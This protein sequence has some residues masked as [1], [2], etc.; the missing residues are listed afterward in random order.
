MTIKK[1]LEDKTLTAIE[2]IDGFNLI[3]NIYTDG[4][5]NGLN[6]DT[7]NINSGTSLTVHEDFTLIDD[8]LSV[9][10]ISIDINEVKML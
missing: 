7:S 10:N 4:I 2:T 3:I 5:C 9:D 6:I 1:F 8:I